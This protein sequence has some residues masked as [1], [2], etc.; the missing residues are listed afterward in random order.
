MAF[1]LVRHFAPLPACAW[2]AVC[3]SGCGESTADVS[4][5]ITIQ[6]KAPDLKELDIGFLGRNGRLVTAAIN[7]D[8]TYKAVGVPVGETMVSFIYTP[9]PSVPATGKHRL[10]RPGP[11]GSPPPPHPGKEADNNPIPPHLRDGSTSKLSFKVVPG[12]N[13][14]FNYDVKP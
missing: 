9:P 6:G 5:K 12:Q 8:G 11:D 7:T 13:N 3:L 2:A 14:V 4:G 10:L 1:S